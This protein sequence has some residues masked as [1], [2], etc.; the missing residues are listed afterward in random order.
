MMVT[1]GELLIELLEGSGVEYIFCS[2]GS[3]WA[4]V[5]EALAK[6][7]ARGSAGLR[8]VNRRHEMLAV[9]VAMGYAECTGKLPAVLL[10]SGIGT[11]HGSMALRTAY[12]AKA[13]IIVLAGETVEH[14][15][16]TEVSPQGWHWLSLLSDVGGPSSFVKGYVKW[17]NGVKSKDGLVS[18]FSRGCR[19]ARATPRARFPVNHPG[20]S[21]P[22]L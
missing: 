1:G 7:E 9:S 8:Y 14:T 18:S 10:H 2:P 3:E 6:R 12:F 21:Y 5:W 20:D 4:P 16:D 11:L 15:G 13:P 22:V 19:M 17:S